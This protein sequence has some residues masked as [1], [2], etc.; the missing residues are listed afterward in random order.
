MYSSC[1]HIEI[2]TTFEHQ[3]FL[4]NTNEQLKQ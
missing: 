4:Y 2:C 1:I 3:V